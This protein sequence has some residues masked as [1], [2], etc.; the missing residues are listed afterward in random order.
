MSQL[1]AS[2]QA[3]VDRHRVN[4]GAD[5]AAF[6]KEQLEQ[7]NRKAEAP[8][9]RF[10]TAP[11]V[12]NDTPVPKGHGFV[13]CIRYLKRA[14]NPGD[15]RGAIREARDG[16][17]GWLAEHWEQALNTQRS[18]DLQLRAAGRDTLGGGGAMV[19][20]DFVSEVLEELGS[21]TVVRRSGIETLPMPHGHLTMPALDTVP[22]SSYIGEAVAST[23]SSPTYVQ[24]TMTAR[25]LMTTTALSN[26]LLDDASPESERSI[27]GAMVRSQARKENITFL[28]GK[29]ASSTP[30]GFLYWAIAANKFDANGSTSL[31]NT[32]IDLAKAINKPLAADVPMDGLC[33]FISPG[34]YQ[35]LTSVQTTTGALAYPDFIGGTLE[36]FPW[37][38]TSAIVD[39]GGGGSNESK[40]YLVNV[41]NGMAIG[42]TKSMEVLLHPYGAFNDSGGSVVSG[43]STDQSVL[44]AIAR[45]DTLA[46]YQGKEVAVI[47]AVKWGRA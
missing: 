18:L 47:E 7:Q 29:G 14:G 24:L 39:T 36:G 23:E 13:R 5:L 34:T 42:D 27:R 44:S 45:H 22:T 21:A 25:K 12:E 15:V 17:D 46:Q 30:K 20:P 35:Y 43:I 31:T 40:I 10:P 37:Y 1:T 6:V 41:K 38:M 16:G 26:E 9:P 11:V 33:W 3:T 2:Q 28:T 8:S 19:P 32:R 4:V